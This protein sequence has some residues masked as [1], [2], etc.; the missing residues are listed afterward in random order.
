[1]IRF[2][3]SRAMSLCPQRRSWFLITF[4]DDVV[5][6]H[7]EWRLCSKRR[8][9]LD[10]VI[11]DMALRLQPKFELHVCSQAFHATL[12]KEHSGF[13]VSRFVCGLITLLLNRHPDKRIRTLFMR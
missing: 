4:R 1:M 13:V 3:L 7:C 6:Q 8:E 5:Q 2:S 11:Q 9:T 12:G 10:P